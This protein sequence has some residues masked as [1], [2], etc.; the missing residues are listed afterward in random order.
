METIRIRAITNAPWPILRVLIEIIACRD[1]T[2]SG[3]NKICE[4]SNSEMCVTLD[5]TAPN[6]STE[7]AQSE[8]LSANGAL[9]VTEARL[10][11][12]LPARVLGELPRPDSA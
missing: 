10:L 2:A 7:S 8:G 5:S 1:P 3:N 6:A 9:A 4:R 12:P 11:K